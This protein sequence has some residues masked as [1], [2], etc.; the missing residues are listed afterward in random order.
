MIARAC[1]VM[2]DG[3]GDP[4]EISTSGSKDARRLAN[5]EGFVR[6]D[7]RDLCWRCRPAVPA[8]TDSH[9]PEDA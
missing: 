5:A 7:G 4:A 8:M 3:C 2:C 9:R 1:Y 6:V